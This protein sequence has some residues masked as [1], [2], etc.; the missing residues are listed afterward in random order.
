M[1]KLRSSK[2][3][4]ALGKAQNPERGRERCRGGDNATKEFIQEEKVCRG[5]EKKYAKIQSE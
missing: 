5:T 1:E 3:G 2:V 4:G